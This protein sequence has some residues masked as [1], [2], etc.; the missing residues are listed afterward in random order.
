MVETLRM[1]EAIKEA[2]MAETDS[3]SGSE[4]DEPKSTL[5]LDKSATTDDEAPSE[6]K[7]HK[8]AL[9]DDE[10]PSGSHKK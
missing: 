9:S 5:G 4:S 7:I 2:E 6:E 8:R 3:S 1:F 10:E